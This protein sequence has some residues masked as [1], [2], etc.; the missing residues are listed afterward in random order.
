MEEIKN[1]ASNKVRVKYMDG[2]EEIYTFTKLR[3]ERKLLEIQLEQWSKID[4][5]I[6]IEKIKLDHEHQKIVTLEILNRLDL[7]EKELNK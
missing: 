5:N 6:E 1:I 2:K 3:N 7:I 4:I